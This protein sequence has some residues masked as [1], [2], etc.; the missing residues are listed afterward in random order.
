MSLL[1]GITAVQTTIRLEYSATINA[2]N[3]HSEC[4]AAIQTINLVFPDCFVAYDSSQ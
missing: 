2:V 3:C 4:S 1:A